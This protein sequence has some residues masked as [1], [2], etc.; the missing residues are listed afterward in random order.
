MNRTLKIVLTL[1]IFLAFTKSNL[2]AQGCV[3]IRSTGGLCTMSEHPDSLA[4]QGSWL[5]NTNS[6]YFNSFRHFVGK[7]EQKQRIEQ[8]TNVINH[9]FTQDFN[10]TRN[11]NNR[12]SLAIDLPLVL[13]NRS[14]LYEHGGASRRS[15]QSA[16]IGDIRLT[17]YR[18]LLNPATAH[19]GNIQVGLGVKLPTGKYGATDDFYNVGANGASR[20]GPVDQSIQPGDGG[21]GI[22]TEINAYYN[23]AHNFGMY[24]TLFY[25]FNPRDV[26]GVSTARGGTPSATAIATT[27]AV[28]SVPDQ[29]LVRIGFSLG[30]KHLDFSAGARYECL[31]V[32]DIIGKSD[33]FRR[34]GYILSAEPG[35]T[36]RLKKFSVYA[37]VPVAVMRD[38]TQSVADMRSTALSGKY[39]HGDAAFADYVINVGASFRF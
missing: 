25:L 36:Y 31:P 37:F 16:G 38:R 8:K 26:N 22:T 34:P 19:N 2:F 39:A 4:V 30:T 23:F 18:W 3:A 35:V 27:S 15:T 10:L 12:W 7:D 5:F 21:W 11:F 1:A 14:S 17:G 29:E 6:R 24:G 13:N 32:K 33:G 9:A 28:M 20:V